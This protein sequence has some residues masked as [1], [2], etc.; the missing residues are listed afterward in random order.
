MKF[1]FSGLVISS[2]G[3]EL[4]YGL[5]MQDM[6][7]NIEMVRK[8]EREFWISQMDQDT[9]ELLLT[10]KLMVLEPTHGLT[11]EFM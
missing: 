4:K 5:T 3:M 1:Y 2:M 9:K 10:M 8:M 7:A 6:K 11:R